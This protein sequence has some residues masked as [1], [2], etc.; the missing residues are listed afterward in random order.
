MPYPHPQYSEQA[1]YSDPAERA[2]GE[3][4]SWPGPQMATTRYGQPSRSA[5]DNGWMIPPNIPVSHP[6]YAY[7]EAR[8]TDYGYGV[9]PSMEKA[10]PGTPQAMQGHESYSRQ[11]GPPEPYVREIMPTN[12]VFRHVLSYRAYRLRN[13]NSDLRSDLRNVKENTEFLRMAMY[14][15]DF[16]GRDELGVLSFLARLTDSANDLEMTESQL[17]RVL[18]HFL[19]GTANERYRGALAF[20]GRSQLSGGIPSGIWSWP[21]AVN[22]LLRTYARDD[23]LDRALTDLRIMSQKP[24]EEEESFIQ[25][26]TNALAKC[27][28]PL[29]P[30]DF[31]ARFVDGLD[32]RI[33][34]LVRRF[35]SQNP[36]SDLLELVDVASG[37]GIAMRARAPRR[38]RPVEHTAPQFMRPTSVLNYLDN[39]GDP[40][41]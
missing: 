13:T 8:S 18:P 41:F 5:H 1:K 6:A 31:I 36:Q 16:S 19:A 40:I 11:L 14:G 29:S 7:N 15:A 27:G 33:K 32:I 25:R 28:Y 2:Y 37:E 39:A 26:L 35:R 3:D 23:A 12:S 20:A 21:S 30:D 10:L 38:E 22:W 34:S 4:P 17:F 24:G 9:H